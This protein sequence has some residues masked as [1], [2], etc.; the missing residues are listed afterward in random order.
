MKDSEFIELLNLYLDHEISTADAARLE[1]EVQSNLSRRKIYQQYCRMQK[2]CKVLA[3]DFQTES[4][5]AGDA[6]AKNV[7]AFDSSAADSARQRRNSG[8]YTV[9]AFAAAA[10]CVA[11]I[12]VGRQRQDTV[13]AAQAAPIAQTAQALDVVSAPNAVMV[14]HSPS[15]SRG[16]L[17]SVAGQ[18]ASAAKSPTS[19][20]DNSL[21]LA[22]N[23]GAESALANAMQQSHDQLEW[24]RNVQLSPLQPRVQA[25][26]LRFGVQPAVLR[27]EPRAVGTSAPAQGPTESV[28][29]QFL[30]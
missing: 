24:V 26:A 14:S 20:G 5:A 12:F 10:A 16:G 23:A 18:R 3:S 9:G 25:E 4:A 11:V 29:F 15:V 2:A 27:P 30:K 22:A 13:S 7:V 6:V 21:L 8:M 17:V 28:G 19:L 1:A